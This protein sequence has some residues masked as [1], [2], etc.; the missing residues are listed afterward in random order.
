LREE[1]AGLGA[2]AKAAMAIKNST[3]LRPHEVIFEVLKTRMSGFKGW[4]QDASLSE[5]AKD[6]LRTG[7]PGR[8]R[9]HYGTHYVKDTDL[10]AWLKV[11]VRAKCSN[12]DAQRT[13]L[14]FLAD[15]FDSFGSSE[16]G[17]F[18]DLIEASDF[19]T[20]VEV[21]ITSG[22]PEIDPSQLLSLDLNKAEDLL[23]NFD[24]MTP[25]GAGIQHA[26]ARFDRHP[27]YRKIMEEAGHEYQE[28]ESREDDDALYLDIFGI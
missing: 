6:M 21:S 9:Y 18:K 17:S 26:L 10:G 25:L 3:Q 12:P 22:G 13:A 1:L 20:D 28:I 14:K 11:T 8:F 5:V 4:V 23:I 19:L 2:T 24:E 7:G 27:D 16:G 15:K